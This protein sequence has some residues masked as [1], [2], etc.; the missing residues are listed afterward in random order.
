M[1][2]RGMRTNALPSVVLAVAVLGLPPTV[3]GQP[4]PEVPLPPG[5]VLRLGS[6][7]FRH[8]RLSEM[9][10]SADGKQVITLSS[11]RKNVRLWD[12]AT[13]K[14]AKEVGFETDDMVLG[15]A[16]SPTDKLFATWEMVRGT[17]PA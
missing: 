5:A 2:V 8:P 12:A 16:W 6:P 7:R 11:V 14:L 4:T 15:V 17:N 9:T 13:G 10:L 3:R 1:K